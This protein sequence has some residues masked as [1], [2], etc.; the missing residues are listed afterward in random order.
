MTHDGYPPQ[1]I[2]DLVDSMRGLEQRAALQYRQVVDDILRTGSRDAQQI[3]HTLD[4]CWT[5]VGTRSWC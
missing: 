5:S 1:A 3:E 4:V 2:L